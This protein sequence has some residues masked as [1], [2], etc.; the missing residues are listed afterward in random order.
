MRDFYFSLFIMYVVWIRGRFELI[1]KIKTGAEWFDQISKVVDIK[2]KIDV[3]RNLNSDCWSVRQG[4]RVVCHVDYITLQ[5]C[6]F[7]VQPAGR[8]RVLIEQKK[9]VH[10]FVRGYLCSPREADYTPAFSWDYVKYNPYKSDSFVSDNSPVSDNIKVK[11]AKF[12]D[13][14][15]TDKHG[16]LAWG[17]T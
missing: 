12:V 5:N 14:D 11:K 7:V 1:K 8:R 6:E 2:R 4:A 16:V 17:S 9:N 3:Y 15:V 10:A 13:M